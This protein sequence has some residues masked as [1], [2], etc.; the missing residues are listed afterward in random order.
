MVFQPTAY[1]S[2]A[3]DAPPPQR[4]GTTLAREHLP[5]SSA[6]PGQRGFPLVACLVVL[7]WWHLKGPQPAGPTST[8]LVLLQLTRGLSCDLPPCHPLPGVI[9]PCTVHK[10]IRE[11]QL[12]PLGPQCL[13]GRTSRR[14][15]FPC[16]LALSCLLRLQNSFD[17]P[18]LQLLLPQEG[19]RPPWL[20]FHCRTPAAGGKRRLALSTRPPVDF[21]FTVRLH[22]SVGHLYRFDPSCQLLFCLSCLQHWAKGGVIFAD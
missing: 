4:D 13:R 6:V 9:F 12:V 18:I 1:R 19:C 14:H 15:I 17:V 2:Y 11:D 20:Q 5:A 16:R 8:G 21:P 10:T 7:R 3:S 22:A